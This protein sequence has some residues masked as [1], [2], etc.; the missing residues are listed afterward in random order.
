ME[1]LGTDS[2]VDE[3]DI[4][5]RLNQHRIAS[6]KYL[7]QHPRIEYIEIDYPTLVKN[8]TMWTPVI[9]DFL[10]NDLLPNEVNMAT[11]IDPQLHRNH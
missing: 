8:P 7:A 11:V 1:R 5:R 2:N 6:L 9:V 4:E 10:G 3:T